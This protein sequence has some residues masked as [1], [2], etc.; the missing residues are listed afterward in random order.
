MPFSCPLF[1]T[2]LHDNLH[3]RITYLNPLE[4]FLY[5]FPTFLA[6]RH[7]H[8]EGG[9]VTLIDLLIQCPVRVGKILL[10]ICFSTFNYDGFECHTVI[11]RAMKFKL[12]VVFT[13]GVINIA[14]FVRW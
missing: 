14:Q 2:I 4:R 11:N 7:A 13:Y 5:P 10:Y 6:H 1:Y 9:S 12:F 8:G 3:D